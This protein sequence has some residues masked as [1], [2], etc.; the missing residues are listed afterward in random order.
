MYF[1][2]ALLAA[3]MPQLVEA[4]NV[5]AS[6]YDQRA[7]KV[8]ASGEPFY[9]DKL[10]VSHKTL[11]FG[12]KVKIRYGEK[13]VVAEVN[14]RGPFIKGRKLDMSRGTAKALG[15]TGIGIVELLTMSNWRE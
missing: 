3:T 5:T 11:P 14:D 4:E 7:G 12:T 9:P 6:W 8:T 1:L 10:T 15:F 2:I 13:T